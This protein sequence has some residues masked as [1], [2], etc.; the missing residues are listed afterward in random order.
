[1]GDD[2]VV[3]LTTNI[4]VLKIIA[5]MSDAQSAA[6]RA[7]FEAVV[8]G[9]SQ[10]KGESSDADSGSLTDSVESVGSQ[11][12]VNS[13]VSSAR[14]R[15][16]ARAK[17]AKQRRNAEVDQSSQVT[18]TV[19]KEPVESDGFCYLALVKPDRQEEWRA[20]L[21]SGPYFACL[22]GMQVA[23][24]VMGW[25]ELRVSR[26]SPGQYHIAGS[27][28]V[29]VY[30]CFA[31]VAGM[32]DWAPGTVGNYCAPGFTGL[33]R[34][35]I[36]KS[37]LLTDTVGFGFQCGCRDCGTEVPLQKVGFTRAGSGVY[38]RSAA[39]GAELSEVRKWF[40]PNHSTCAVM[41]LV[42]ADAESRV[43]GLQVERMSAQHSISKVELRKYNGAGLY[44]FV[45]GAWAVGVPPRQAVIRVG[46]VNVLPNDRPL[47]VSG[48]GPCAVVGPPGEH[49][50]LRVMPNLRRFVHLLQHC[51][52]GSTEG[53][54]RYKLSPEYAYKPPKFGALKIPTR[55]EGT[56]DELEV[57]EAFV[58]PKN[59]LVVADI[60]THGS[61]V[62]AGLTNVCNFP[63]FQVKSGSVYVCRGGGTQFE[64]SVSE[65]RAVLSS[66]TDAYAIEDGG[67]SDDDDPKYASCV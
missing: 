65:D 64:V 3:S 18:Y 50:Y 48:R 6:A 59:K 28:P 39:V 61:C 51:P 17:L 25:D 20:K 41:E 62:V 67:P 57:G 13:S 55:L 14:A 42:E 54:F 4:E 63:E 32:A 66:G 1:M 23:D 29:D 36:E 35:M 53:A 38:D 40:S 24:L 15:K 58:M 21:G 37:P 33:S 5:A 12:S 47:V 49:V 44:E 34:I 27:G 60:G 26:T 2:A 45:A 31:S 8:V 30:S 9:K 46:G 22:L 11:V 19:K 16:R 7:W 43:S 52:V 10:V 56:E